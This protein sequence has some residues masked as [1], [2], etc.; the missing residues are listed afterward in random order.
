MRL[1]DADELLR[2]FIGVEDGWIDPSPYYTAEELIKSAPT[3][4]IRRG[5]TMKWDDFVNN[6][7]VDEYNNNREITDID[8]PY[9][10]KRKI[11]VRNDI[12]YTS[13]PPQYRYE[14]DCGW[15]GFGPAYHRY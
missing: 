8:C 3:V 13:I 5:K 6:I 1:I 9:C 4:D 15:S 12:I 14:C 11:Y 7:V 10:Q 2:T